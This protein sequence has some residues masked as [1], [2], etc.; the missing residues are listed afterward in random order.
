[1]KLRKNADDGRAVVRFCIFKLEKYEYLYIKTGKHRRVFYRIKG[2][3]NAEFFG[4]RMKNEVFCAS[5]GK[6]VSK[7]SF[8]AT[9]LLYIYFGYGMIIK[10][11]LYSSQSVPI[12]K[13]GLKILLRAY[14]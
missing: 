11:A 3:E 14:R 8:F 7:L 6:H 1:M 13:K 4:K 12:S 9:S 5:S 2:L 10:V